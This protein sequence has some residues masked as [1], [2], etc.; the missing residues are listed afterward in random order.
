MTK[1]TEPESLQELIADCGAI[2]RMRAA[3]TA[4]ASRAAETAPAW[5]IDERCRQHVAE[6][7]E[8]V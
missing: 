7:D 2:P 1:V 6:L 5:E 8:Y 3:A 4:T